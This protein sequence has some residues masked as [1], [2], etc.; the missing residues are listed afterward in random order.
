MANY[1]FDRSYFIIKI[2]KS[3]IE[4]LSQSDHKYLAKGLEWVTYELHDELLHQ[5]DGNALE[6]ME[7]IKEGNQELES[8]FNW[9]EEYSSFKQKQKQNIESV[10]Q[11]QYNSNPGNLFLQTE[12]SLDFTLALETPK[13]LIKQ[14]NTAFID[15]PEECIITI[16]EPTFDIFKLENEVGKENTLSTVSCYI[17]STM[18]LYSIINYA[19]FENFLQ[20]ITKGYTRNN[21]YHNVK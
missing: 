1:L 15:F 21:H 7:R 9:L 12:K 11:K 17:F 19:K 13:N 6:R 8:V 2:L 16:E 5:A 14:N 4:K 20:V 18:G 10:I 3:S